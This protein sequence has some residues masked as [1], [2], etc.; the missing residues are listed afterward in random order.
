MSFTRYRGFRLPAAIA[1][2]AV[3]ALIVMINLWVA[4]RLML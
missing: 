3:A 2:W 4:G 1:L